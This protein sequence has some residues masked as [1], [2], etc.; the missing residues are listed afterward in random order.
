MYLFVVLKPFYFGNVEQLGEGYELENLE[1][2][3]LT[4]CMRFSQVYKSEEAI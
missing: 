3:S 1:R 2:M 4:P